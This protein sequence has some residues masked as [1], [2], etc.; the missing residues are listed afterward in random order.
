MEI[1]KLI[2]IDKSLQIVFSTRSYVILA[3]TCT[4]EI[5]Q[6]AHVHA[7]TIVSIHIQHKTTNKERKHV[8]GYNDR[9]MRR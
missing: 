7:V 2:V 4:N 3:H 6:C 8:M 9:D 5:I 1:K